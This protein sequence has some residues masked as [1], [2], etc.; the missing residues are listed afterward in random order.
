MGY[1]NW[2]LVIYYDTRLSPAGHLLGS[3]ADGDVLIDGRLL[4]RVI[5][6]CADEEKVMSTWA[7]EKQ[8]GG[9]YAT[10]LDMRSGDEVHLP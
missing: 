4:R 10:L 2:K 1:R 9:V 7:R 8:L 3:S 6:L 5:I